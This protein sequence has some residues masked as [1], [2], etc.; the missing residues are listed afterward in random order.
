MVLSAESYSK[1][2]T[3]LLYKI[4]T[5]IFVIG[6]I[7]I[8]ILSAIVI[9]RSLCWMTAGTLF[10]FTTQMGLLVYFSR[11]D[12]FEYKENI[13]FLST[14]CYVLILGTIF[15]SISDYYDNDTFMFSKL[16]AMLYYTESMKVHNGD[17]STHIAYIMKH[18]DFD[19]WGAIL[20]DSMAMY[21]VPNKLFLNFIYMITG[22]ISA[23][24]LFR[25]GKHYMSDA[26]AYIAALSY[27]TSSHLIYYYC[28]FLKEAMFTFIIICTVYFIDQLIVEK[29]NSAF[30]GIIISLFLLMFYRPA[31][32]AFV[33]MGFLSYFAVAKRGSAISVF[34]YIGIAGGLV[35]SLAAMQS[36]LD[37]Y[38]HGG[39]MDHIVEYGTKENYSSGFTYFVSLF[40]ALFGPLPTLFPKIEGRPITINFYGAGLTYRTFLIL[41]YWVGLYFAIKR[42]N[43]Y[44]MPMIVFV[45]IEML[46]TG[47]VMA[48]QELRKVLP[49]VPFMYIIMFYGLYEWQSSDLRKRL[50]GSYFYTFA[51][52]LLILWT[53]IRKG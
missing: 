1:I 13:L 36:L 53:A 45:T 50:P 4:N 31:V 15:M 26:Y 32:A 8:G 14:F 5:D 2:T 16:D 24:L 30:G 51:I 27:A 6:L 41:F 35:V 46:A 34:L 25:I 23:I 44:M 49:H 48:S 28:S 9:D 19:D 37:L 22:C 10:A 33:T 11:E 43:I 42:R 3:A 29:R 47:I 20:F 39:D 52:S 7:T 18:H 40:S 38:T 12:G 17:V 21:L